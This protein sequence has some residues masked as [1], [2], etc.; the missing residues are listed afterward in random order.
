MGRLS[1]GIRWK[2]DPGWVVKL[3]NL[4]LSFLQFKQTAQTLIMHV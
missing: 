2:Y 1:V 3:F 4:T